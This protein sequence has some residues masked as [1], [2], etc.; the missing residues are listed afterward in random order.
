MGR[1]DGGEGGEGGEGKGG[2][3]AI[4]L[5]TL[6]QGTRLDYFMCS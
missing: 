6:L 5:F 1:G 4:L 2:R 3:G